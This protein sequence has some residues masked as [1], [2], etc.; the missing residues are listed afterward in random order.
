MPMQ[1]MVKANIGFMKHC[2]QRRK[3]STK[4]QICEFILLILLLFFAVDTNIDHIVYSHRLQYFRNVNIKALLKS[5]NSKM[6]DIWDDAM[7]NPSG[8]SKGNEK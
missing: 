3:T 7:R 8:C 2:I 5:D 6:S 1:F 4:R